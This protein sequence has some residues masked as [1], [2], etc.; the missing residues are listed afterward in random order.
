MS[1]LTDEQA[2]IIGRST[3][4][5]SVSGGKD[6]T[7]MALWLKYELK[8]PRI[9]YV[10]ADTG[11]EA[12]ETYEYIDGPLTEKLGTIDRVGVPGGMVAV[13]KQ[14][15]MFP[16][17]IRRWCTGD[18][19]LNPIKK[20]IEA[21]QDEGLEIINA[22]GIRA[23]ESSARARMRS[24]EMDDFLDCYVWRPIMIATEEDVIDLHKHHGLLP[25]PLYLQGASR[26]GCWP[27]I[28]SAKADIALTAK[29]SP[30]R[31]DQIRQLESELTEIAKKKYGDD[32]KVSQRTFFQAQGNLRKERDNTIDKVVQWATNTKHG[33]RQ[34]ELY[35]VDREPG[36]VKWGLCEH[37]EKKG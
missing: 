8:H 25:N 11:W 27:C 19:K 4:V 35:A 9:R 34:Y 17:F 36:C 14:K 33:G 15:K 2:E 31:I 20:Y 23:E 1:I 16:S 6:S 18:L 12:K 32:L 26:V 24:F 21:L 30:E 7:A 10:F 29:L 28:F 5:A 13:I 37:L 22:V 3:I